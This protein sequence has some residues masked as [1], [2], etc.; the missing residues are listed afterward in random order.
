LGESEQV[1]LTVTTD[2]YPGGAEYAYA[3]L[4][5]E[6]LEAGTYQ[7]VVYARDCAGQTDWTNRIYYFK[8]AAP[9]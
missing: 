5:V 9:Q 7:L 4:P 8:V 1:W 3:E 2:T 6:S